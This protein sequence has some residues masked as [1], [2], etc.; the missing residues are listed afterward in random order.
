MLGLLSL[1]PVGPQHRLWSAKLSTLIQERQ[2][3]ATFGGRVKEVSVIFSQFN[4][5]RYSEKNKVYEG[6]MGI[7]IEQSRIN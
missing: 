4:W 6:L 1:M 3:K 5:F 2:T 7:F